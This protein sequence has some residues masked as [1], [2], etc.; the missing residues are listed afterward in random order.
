MRKILKGQ[1]QLKMGTAKILITFVLAGGVTIFPALG[2]G[3]QSTISDTLHLG[4]V[5]REVLAHNDQISAARFM[6]KSAKAKIGQSGAWDDPMLMVGVINLPT[7]FN[8]KEDA[9]TMEMVG[10]S[11][12]IPYAGYKG[13][14][15]KAARSEAEV[16][17]E[18]TKA[19]IVDL[20]SAAGYAYINLYYRNLNLESMKTQRALMQDIVSA[21][22]A[23]LR[24]DRGSQADVVL[25]QADL[26]RLESEILSS[27]KEAEAAQNNLLSLMGR[28]SG[29]SL[30]SLSEPNLA[31][32]S[33][34]ADDWI[35]KAKQTYPPLQKMR[36][37]AE[38]YNFNASAAQR[39]RWPMMG[40]SASYGIRQD[41][42]ASG[43]PMSPGITKRDNMFSF[44]LNLS[45]PIFSGRAQGKMA[46][47]MDYMKQGTILEASQMER[48]ISAK[49][50][51]LYRQSQRLTQSLTLYRDRIIPA[52]R[53]AYQSAYAGYISSRMP[54]TNL[55][56]YAVNI[57]RDQITANNVAYQ[58][59]QTYIDVEKYIKIP[60]NDN[61]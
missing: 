48:E 35:S 26:W 3:Q 52:D 43:D 23:R 42:P 16:A 11:Q 7:T 14:L 38:G 56:N 12:N 25:A 45:L 6:E 55:L 34:S 29:T 31:F 1:I 17:A 32:N 51:T 21:A 5:I 36:R 47:S 13:L 61:K 40:L 19:T 54:F 15:N 50:R 58:L 20:A 49:L 41:A 33:P 57:Y 2:F 18:D 37:Q 44:Q 46:R 60:S 39:M 9:M 30:P 53:D 59:A 28:E 27:E 8:F 4:D 24:T 10:I 22:T